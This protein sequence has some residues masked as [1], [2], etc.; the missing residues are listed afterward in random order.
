MM[1]TAL[2]L[3]LLLLTACS[4]SSLAVTA[5]EEVAE[6]STRGKKD[7]ASFFE[8]VESLPVVDIRE[9]CGR[10]K[11]RLLVFSDGSKACCKYSE[12]AKQQEGELYAYHLSNLLHIAGV[13]PVA[14]AT[15]NFS[16]SQ[17]KRVS[18]KARNA[19]WS[20]GK[21]LVLTEFVENLQDEYY[22]TEFMHPDNKS[23]LHGEND[24]FPIPPAAH[25]PSQTATSSSRLQQWSDVILFDYITGHTDRLF[26]SLVNMQWAPSV[27]HKPVHNLGKTTRGTGTLVL[28]DNESC[29]TIGYRALRNRY[30]NSKL[31]TYFIDRL[32][33]FNPRT[34]ESLRQHANKE[35]DLMAET[36]QRLRSSS[37]HYGQPLSPHIHKLSQRTREEFNRRTLYILEQ[38]D[39]CN[40][41]NHLHKTM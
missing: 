34:I 15:L 29:F 37:S 38:F 26:C 4:C 21:K 40:N 14:L 2:S 1:K 11:N 18:E 27:L 24:T 8:K 22:P 35:R 3:L 19:D 17:W 16:G 31:Q 32:C 36:D 12:T 28:Y 39:K 5:P 20:N 10:V 33:T 30:D 9:G 6:D 13:P 25:K 7:S 23:L 41:S